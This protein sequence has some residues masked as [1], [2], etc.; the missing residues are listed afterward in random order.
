[1]NNLSVF[2]EK[3]KAT[4]HSDKNSKKYSKMI[5]SLPIGSHLNNGDINYI[6][7]SIEMFYFKNN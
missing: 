4:V 1:L 7:D 2:N 6:C 5:L 3:I